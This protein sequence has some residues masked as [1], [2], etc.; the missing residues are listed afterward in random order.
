P[1]VGS[2]LV[3]LVTIA[4]AIPLGVAAGVYLE[5]YARKNWLTTVIEINISNLASVPSILYGLMA[6]GGLGY[7]LG[8]N[9]LPG[10]LT[11]AFLTLPIVI[12]A[13]REALRAIPHTI[14]EAA[15]A[16]GATRWQVVRH[17]LLPYSAGGI[18][19]GVIIGVSRALGETAP[20]VTIGAVVFIN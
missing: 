3:I 15:T 10:G 8:R 6:L 5:E 1:M 20:L 4:A 2:F 12:G 11:L 13:P 14:R 18:S 16:L 17:H 19:T 7:F 9:L